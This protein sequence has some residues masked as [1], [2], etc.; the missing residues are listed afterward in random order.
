[1]TFL[2]DVNLPRSLW[3]LQTQDFIFAFNINQQLSDSESWKLA[4]SNNYTILTRDM[5]FYYRAKESV[6]FPKII[7]FRF[8]NLKLNAMHQY[9]LQNWKTI[10]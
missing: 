7:I 5:D 6:E 10:F 8:G 2:V 3:G 4:M 1:M 9:F